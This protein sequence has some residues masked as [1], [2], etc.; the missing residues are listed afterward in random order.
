MCLAFLAAKPSLASPL[1]NN[2][3]ILPKTKCMDECIKEFNECSQ[4][5]VDVGWYVALLC[6]VG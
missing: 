5:M 3:G 2:A 6:V 1:P 4:T